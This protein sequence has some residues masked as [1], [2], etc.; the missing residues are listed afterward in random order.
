M[1][2]R[3]QEKRDRQYAVLF[4]YLN[5]LARHQ[6]L[7]QEIEPRFEPDQ[8]QPVIDDQ[9]QLAE[10]AKLGVKIGEKN[11]EVVGL[12]REVA[13]EE[14]K[15]GMYSRE[16]SVQKMRAV[17]RRFLNAGREL[18]A[19]ERKRLGE[20]PS[21][22]FIRN[23]D[24]GGC[25][26]ALYQRP[27]A[28]GV[29]ERLPD[30]RPNFEGAQLLRCQISGELFPSDDIKVSHIVPPFVHSRAFGP[31]LF[32][33]DAEP[34]RGSGNVLLL[35]REI[36]KWY[37][38]YKLVIVPFDREET[39]IRRWKTE[40]I[41]SR[42]NR[43]RFANEGAPVSTFHSRELVFDNEERPVAKFAYFHFVMAL[44]RAKM[45]NCD[46]W[47]DIWAKYWLNPPFPGGSLYIRECILFALFTHFSFS[48]VD[49]AM[50]SSW[51]RGNGFVR[52]H[53]LETFH[54]CEKDELARRILA[55]VEAAVE[56][57]EIRARTVIFPDDSDL[58]SDSEED[59]S[60]TASE[61][62]EDYSGEE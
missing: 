26:L 53:D 45:L 13:I 4:D 19:Y 39:P 24:F 35:H 25:M 18:W 30:W 52:L 6:G 60:E 62:T 15:L 36:K 7:R 38:T 44:V 31:L 34:L 33:P 2:D 1:A 46:R 47:Q 40:I 58:E 59:Y 29:V 11:K 8:L 43:E 50:I 9:A 20:P 28:R 55:G 17:C 61:S 32:G 16:V 10:L 5:L 57:M 22:F 14:I 23:F 51:I 12:E 42:L 27:D 49:L 41:S 21:E 54:G 56:K 48:G 37:G 3:V